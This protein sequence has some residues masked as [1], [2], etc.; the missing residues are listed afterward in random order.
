M[1]QIDEFHSHTVNGLHAT[2]P[3]PI[4]DCEDPQ[5]AEDRAGIQAFARMDEEW[6]QR[7]IGLYEEAIRLDLIALSR[8]REALKLRTAS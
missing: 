7:Q 8:L 6:L 1:S 2:I 4:R 5:C 3:G